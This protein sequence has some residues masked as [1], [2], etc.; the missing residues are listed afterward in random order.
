MEKKKTNNEKKAPSVKKRS[1]FSKLFSGAGKNIGDAA[2][3]VEKKILQVTDALDDT[4]HDSEMVIEMLGNSV[5]FALE[6]SKVSIKT[7]LPPAHSITS[8]V[9]VA[10][11]DGF[12][13]TNV[14]TFI[15]LLLQKFVTTVKMFS[16]LTNKTVVEGTFEVPGYTVKAIV[17]L[18]PKTAIK[19]SDVQLLVKK[20]ES[21][22]ATNPEKTVTKQ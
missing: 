5:N 4:I 2:D 13:F 3:A 1:I 14:T 19:L 18:N 17:E 6:T 21:T 9:K 10:L 16:V 20:N 7:Y 12:V 15:A 11:N 22:P 8:R